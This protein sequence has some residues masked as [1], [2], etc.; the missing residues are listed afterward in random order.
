MSHLPNRCNRQRGNRGYS[1][2]FWPNASIL[3]LPARLTRIAA[4]NRAS[5]RLKALSKQVP[6]NRVFW[7]ATPDWCGKLTQ[8]ESVGG[9]AH[10][11]QCI[12]FVWSGGGAAY[13]NGGA[14][15]F[16]RYASRER[17]WRLKV[18]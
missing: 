12:C 9:R 14:D 8:L 5:A 3:P 10:E 2:D 4:T 11:A 18:L 16:S 15:A 17:Q 13:R 7:L 1:V 6:S